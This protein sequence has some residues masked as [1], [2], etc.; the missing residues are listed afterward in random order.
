VCHV[1][2]HVKWL[3]EPVDIPQKGQGSFIKL[4]AEKPEHRTIAEK[5]YEQVEDREWIELDTSALD[6]LREKLPSGPAKVNDLSPLDGVSSAADGLASA[7]SSEARAALTA[8]PAVEPSALCGDQ[9]AGEETAAGGETGAA[10]GIGQG[11]AEPAAEPAEP[12]ET[13]PLGTLPSETPPS[14]TPPS[15]TLASETPP[16]EIPGE[17]GDGEETAPG[18]ETGTA[19]GSERGS[20][21]DFDSDAAGDDRD[22]G[23]SSRGDTG[24]AGSGT[25]IQ[26]AHGAAHENGPR[27]GDIGCE[28][29]SG[30]TG[31]AGS[32][33]EI[34]IAHGAAHEEQAETA[35]EKNA[36]RCKQLALMCRDAWCKV[37]GRAFP[38]VINP[39]QLQRGV[40]RFFASDPT[41]SHDDELCEI[42]AAD[43][44]RSVLQLHDVEIRRKQ[45]K[46]EAELRRE[47]D[48]EEGRAR[49]LRHKVECEVINRLYPTC[50]ACTPCRDAKYKSLEQRCSAHEEEYRR[51]VAE[52]LK[53][54]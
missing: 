28:Q 47:A 18:E 6:T 53:C 40:A 4:Y 15:E 12:S 35:E 20:S 36:K 45:E 52:R 3:K 21:P 13:L 49:A 23:Q 32:G 17:Q 9:G 42:S 33:P 34:Q 43:A 1:I 26:F 50:K 25:E 7:F 30:A 22:K 41:F 27:D 31:V 11:L 16:S 51:L 19:G 48:S 14:E 5:V 29:A 46:M 10:G 54:M 8:E 39:W 44:V 38:D 37:E 24:S 2:T